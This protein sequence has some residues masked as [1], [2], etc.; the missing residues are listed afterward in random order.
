MK[1]GTKLISKGVAKPI[2]RKSTSVGGVD[3]F[4]GSNQYQP[5]ALSIQP[6]KSVP[7]RPS[8]GLPK[9]ANRPIPPFNMPSKAV[10]PVRR[11]SLGLGRVGVV[12][13]P[14]NGMFKVTA[15]CPGSP[16]DINGIGIGDRIIKIDGKVARHMSKID[17][18]A[19][20]RGPIGSNVKLS[21][22]RQGM[23]RIEEIFIQRAKCAPPNPNYRKVAAGRGSGYAMSPPYV[24]QPSSSY[25]TSSYQAQPQA[26]YQPRGAYQQPVTPQYG[27]GVP[28]HQSHNQGGLSSGRNYRAVPLRNHFIPVRVMFEIPSA[29]LIGNPVMKFK[30]DGNQL[31]APANVD[32]KPLPKGRTAT[33]KAFYASVN[34]DPGSYTVIAKFSKRHPFQTNLHRRGTATWKKVIVGNEPVAIRLINGEIKIA[35]TA[36]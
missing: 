15:L 11:S 20:L 18:I 9:P 25:P 5:S 22:I 13:E 30:P 3:I 26:S 34:L 14:A 6:R 36:R 35:A 4:G 29:A 23:S 16:A 2:P 27:Q 33:T 21:V 28:M 7:P 12:L 24:K 8:F 31:T 17:A 10:S 19:K 32:T 1:D